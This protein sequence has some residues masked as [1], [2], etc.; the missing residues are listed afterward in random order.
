[1]NRVKAEKE[2]RRRE[3][4]AGKSP[5]EIEALDRED[6]LLEQIHALARRIHADRFPEESDE[7][8][9][10]IYDAERRSRG[11]NPM[12]EQ[13]IARVAEKRRREGVSPLKPNGLPASRDTWELAYRE[14]ESR[15]RR[16]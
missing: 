5:A 13:Y 12:S 10:S 3:A 7:V 15:L 1:M 16:G 2:R 11:E 6:A 4:R 8:G 9:D 14:A